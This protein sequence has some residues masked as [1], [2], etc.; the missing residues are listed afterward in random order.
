MKVLTTDGRIVEG[1]PITEEQILM[2]AELAL[3]IHSIVCPNVR[4][5]DRSGQSRCQEAADSMVFHYEIKRLAAELCPDSR[6]KVFI[7]S[8]PAPDWLRRPLVKT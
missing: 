4:H 7:P 3:L 6:G 2:R 1:M 8:E 5:D